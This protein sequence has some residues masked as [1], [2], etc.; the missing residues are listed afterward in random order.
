MIHNQIEAMPVMNSDV[1]Q[2][3]RPHNSFKL[4]QPRVCKISDVR[5]NGATIDQ[6]E[7]SVFERQMRGRRHCS[8]AAQARNKPDPNMTVSGNASTFTNSTSHSL[9]NVLTPSGTFSAAP[10]LPV[11]AAARVCYAPIRVAPTWERW[12][13]S[14]TPGCQAQSRPPLFA[15]RRIFP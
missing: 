11:P 14:H 10:T 7:V 5:E 8:K 15:P 1:K 6:I 13:A 4:E 9:F 2:S 12:G 3:T